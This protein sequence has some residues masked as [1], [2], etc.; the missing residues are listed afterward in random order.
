MLI[1]PTFLPAFDP[2]SEM[3][4]TII[5]TVVSKH[6]LCSKP[7]ITSYDTT[8]RIQFRFSLLQNFPFHSQSPF[9]HHFI[10]FSSHYLFISFPFLSF[11]TNNFPYEDQ[12]LS[13]SFS[14]KNHHDHVSVLFSFSSK[15]Y[16]LI[17]I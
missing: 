10:T 2:F 12:L 11:A 13:S 15:I 1:S 5:T 16:I 9:Q 14:E 8:R 3:F 17:Y 6:I 4:T 7:I